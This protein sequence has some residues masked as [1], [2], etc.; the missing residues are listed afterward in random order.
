MEVHALD[1]NPWLRI[2]EDLKQDAPFF[3]T[4]GLIFGFMQFW[5]YTYFHGAEWGSDLLMEH[6]PF[7][8]LPLMAITV[9]VTKSVTTWLLSRWRFR[10]LQRVIDHLIKR[11]IAFGSVPACV[12][13]G[14]AVCTA[15]YGAYFYAAYFVLAG[16]YF[17]ALAEVSAN[18]LH[19]AEWSEANGLAV[20]LI[21][22]TPVI[23]V[24][25]PVIKKIF[26]L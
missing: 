17:A 18:P 10:H 7:Q 14:F 8:S 13:I 25:L 9:W 2:A 1:H 21:T 20:I 6:I 3:C 23:F 19:R 4:I 16:L 12:I 24:L 22:V 26:H 5:G 11:T 15:I